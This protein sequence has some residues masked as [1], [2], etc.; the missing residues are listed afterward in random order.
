M[1]LAVIGGAG[2]RTPLLVR[3]L[4]EAAAALPIEEISL[5]DPDGERLELMRRVVAAMAADRG[6]QARM[7]AAATAEAAIAGA[8]YVITSIRAGGIAARAQDERIAL[9]H[10]LV[11]QETVGAGG[12]AGAL[13]NLRAMLPYARTVQA[14]APEATIINFTN[15]VG[16]VSQALLQTGVR[17]LG[18][19]DTPLETFEQIAHA[20]GRDPFTL[21][22]DYLGLNHLGWVRAIR[23]G[24]PAGA[25]LLPDLLRSP[26]QLRQC[27]RHGL[28]PP[29]FLQRLG[30]L[31]TEY[32]YFYYFAEQA[33]QNTQ[34]SQT[35]RGAAIEILNQ[36]LF[37]QLGQASE[38]DILGVY[39]DYLRRRNAS[40]FSIEATAGAHE[41]DRPLYSQFSGYERIAVLLLT[42][43]ASET[44]KMVPLTVR[45]DAGGRAAL[46][47]LE[48]E[49]AVELLCQVS[50][51]GIEP[52]R[53][54]PAPK[55]V[56]D[57]L[58][59]VKQYERLV[60]EAAL[61]GNRQR[62]LEA[63][64]TNP[65]VGPA[66]AEPVLRDYEAAFGA[67]LG[68]A[69][70]GQRDSSSSAG[71]AAAINAAK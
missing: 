31:P 68:L 24:G 11:G 27:Y 43:L 71:G 64:E 62:A 12:C 29:E 34:N 46:S 3:G 39:E 35:S 42:A 22:F 59:R 55:A 1:K 18:V 2:V 7:P 21:W 65:L 47:D 36:E 63:L 20:L 25:D 33:R 56:N 69:A 50:R 58:Q 60:A 8:S 19:C 52:A 44:A 45:N 67:D 15:P 66:S 10:G 70:A 53:P 13:R 30:V 49:D 6:L 38:R 40:Y 32:L 51:R 61:T 57:L 41:E 16:I 14:R 5:Y 37:R 4:A 54:G 23:A 48:P 26:A 28:F 9:A 17:I